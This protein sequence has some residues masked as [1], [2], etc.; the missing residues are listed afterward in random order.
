MGELAGGRRAVDAAGGAGAR[1]G[2]RVALEL[3]RGLLALPAPLKRLLSGR[4]PIRRDGL[5]LDPEIQLL[6]ALLG[7]LGHRSFDQMS[8]A[9]ARAEV[10]RLAQGFSGGAPSLARVEDRS[11]PG[12]AGALPVRHYVPAGV[13]HPAPLVVYYHGGGWVVGSLASHDATCRFLAWEARVPVLAVDYRLAPEHRF[14]AALEDALAALR[15]AAAEHAVLGVDPARIAVAGDSAGGNLA[16]AV[17]RLARR[18]AA[19]QPAF[20]LLLYP[21]TDLSA[22]HPSYRLFPEGFFLTEG[23]MDWYR[24]HYLPDESAALDPRASPLLAPDLAGLPPA[25]VVTAGFDVLRDEGEAYARALERA[26]VPVRLERHA[27]L[28]HGFANMFVVSRSCRAAMRA[29]ATALSRALGD[30]AESP[31]RQRPR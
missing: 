24:G 27:G 17:A 19:P 30:V 10:E 1:A 25:L 16:A 8:P 9:E 15:W 18:E 29:A 3:A 14:P 12:P 2:S 11:I 22:K 6:L 31:S 26:G 7:W 4:R 23:E 5:T 13:A 28:I 21:V 20:Q